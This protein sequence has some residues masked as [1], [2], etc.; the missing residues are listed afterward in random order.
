M[1]KV[2]AGETRILGTL[3]EIACESGKIRFEIVSNDGELNLTSK[4]F[5]SLKI[6]AYTNV[7]GLQIGCGKLKKPLFGVFSY[8]KTLGAKKKFAGELLAIELV[9]KGFKILD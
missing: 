6:M 3:N 4:D 5:Q 8:K 2:G 1:R 9:P 7:G